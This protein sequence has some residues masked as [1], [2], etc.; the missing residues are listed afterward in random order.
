[1]RL[2]GSESNDVSALL[3]ALLLLFDASLLLSPLF[4]LTDIAIVLFI[5]PTSPFHKTTFGESNLLLFKA[6]LIV[7]PSPRA[8]VSRDAGVVINNAPPL[9]WIIAGIIRHAHK[10]VQH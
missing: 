5:A 10:R 8:T 9:A 7:E 2:D 6:Q 1:M 4:A 3:A